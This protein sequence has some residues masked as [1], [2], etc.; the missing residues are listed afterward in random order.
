MQKV[1][2]TYQENQA[3]DLAEDLTVKI[4]WDE[5]RGHYELDYQKGM[6]GNKC[7]LVDQNHELDAVIAN[8][9]ACQLPVMASGM[10]GLDGTTYRLKI[11]ESPSVQFTWWEELPN[12]WAALS[13]II[14]K[15]N[16]MVERD[17]DE[18]EKQHGLF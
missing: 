10:V 11:G 4:I 6:Y 16:I 9:I 15:I 7:C 12:E 2:I 8:A 14:N 5:D 13:S 3:L 1:E 18:S 17:I